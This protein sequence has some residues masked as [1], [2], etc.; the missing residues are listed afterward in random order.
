MPTF[1]DPEL[2]RDDPWLKAC[3]AASAEPTRLDPETPPRQPRE[4]GEDGVW[5]LRFRNRQGRLCKVRATTRDVRG[6]SAPACCRPWSRPAVP[7]RRNSG[8]S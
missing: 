4:P 7:N 3:Q 2:A 1:A 6:A 5:L 8:R